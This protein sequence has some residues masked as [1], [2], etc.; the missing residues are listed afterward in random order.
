M[1][2]VRASVV[3]AYRLG[4]RGRLMVMHPPNPLAA[5]RKST[6]G[7]KR[8]GCGTVGVAGGQPLPEARWTFS[9][10][11]TVVTTFNRSPTTREREDQID[12]GSA[13]ETAGARLKT[14]AHP[15]HTR[16]GG[17]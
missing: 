15:R 3:W 13:E 14:S 9:R 6:P 11:T 12:D 17:G 16:E 8:G 5:K 7:R 1:A 10:V 4:G 2:P